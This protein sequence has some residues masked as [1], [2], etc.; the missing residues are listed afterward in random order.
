MGPS[1]ATSVGAQ[2][3]TA[4]AAQGGGYIW[5][6]SG[7]AQVVKSALP[8]LP[9]SVLRGIDGIIYID[10]GAIGGLPLS[11]N[12]PTIAVT[13]AGFVSGLAGGATSISDKILQIPT[14]CGHTDLE[15]FQAALHYVLNHILT[16]PARFSSKPCDNPQVFNVPLPRSNYPNNPFGPSSYWYWYGYQPP[17]RPTPLT[18]PTIIWRAGT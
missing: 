8:K 10:P 4:M 2:A 7:G 9:A 6:Y 3:I 5:A 15:C 12:G 18:P 11:P 1:A 14:K 16:P 13:G 17:Q